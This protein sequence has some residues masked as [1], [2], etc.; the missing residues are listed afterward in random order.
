ME[1]KGI[2]L[3]GGRGTRLWPLTQ[4]TSKQLLPVFDKPMIYYPLATL[5]TSK[6][7]K[8]LI[9]TTP[10]DENQFRE[11]FGDGSR[12]GIELDYESQ[13]APNGIAEALIIGENFLEGSNCALILGDNLFYGSSKIKELPSLSVE[14]G[15]VIF[16]HEVKDPSRYGVVEIDS[17]GNA[18]NIVEKPSNPKSNLAVS[19]LYLY[20]SQAS[21]Y[22]KSLTPSVRGELEITDLNCRYLSDKN[23][24]VVILEKES[25]WLDAGTVDSLHDAAS[26]VKA[27]Q[28]RQG[29]QIAC[30]EEIGILNGWLTLDQALE[31]SKKFPNSSY[32]KYL[33]NLLPQS[34]GR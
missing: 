20:D 31:S 13:P 26:F 25:T 22:A 34:V 11:L 10:E 7:R 16:A 15:C 18:K 14:S 23:L 19:G 32:S 8:I 30:L 17:Q 4:V 5:M 29:V 1:T 27:V 28:D 21:T 24:K 2:I 3:A 9:I 33:L 12:F 6:I